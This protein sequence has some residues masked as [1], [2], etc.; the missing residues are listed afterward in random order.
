[1]IGYDWQRS[2]R[3]WQSGDWGR[4]RLQAA[5]KARHL[6]HLAEAQFLERRL[7][8]SL[9]KELTCLHHRSVETALPDGTVL[10]DGHGLHGDDLPPTHM[11]VGAV[12][13]TL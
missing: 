11:V 7:V 5:T 2:L 9:C 10:P 4:F 1:M 3:S 13:S 12:S 8:E 6:G